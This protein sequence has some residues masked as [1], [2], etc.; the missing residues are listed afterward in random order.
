MTA[1]TK[2]DAAH[3]RMAAAP[4]DDAARLGF[5]ER[6]AD[7]ELFLLLEEMSEGERITPRVFDT[8]EGRFVLGF[9]LE[10]RLAAFAGGA[11][12]YAALSG[13]AVAAM[14]AG[15]GIGLGLNLDVAPSSMLL[16]PEALAWLA[17]TLSA[18]P[19]VINARP[20]EIAPP[21]SVPES[22]L[23]ALDVKL[24]SAEGLAEFAYLVSAI[25]ENGAPGHMLAVVDALPG[26]EP[27]LARA[28]R[29]ALVFSGLEAG[30]LAVGFF[31][32]SDP[33][34]ARFAKVGLRFDI[35]KPRAARHPPPPGMD[36]DAPPR[37]G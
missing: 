17:E 31:R 26:A 16:P 9:D 23:K 35:P 14:I 34:S 5:F 1:E 20:R 27:A 12:P 32:A 6:V 3:A 11:A 15:R 18:E 8:D 29:E 7:G 21:R 25:W 13:R 24:A 19:E 37:L 22:L 33:I 2:I 36:P 10:E 30:D 28:T 4:D